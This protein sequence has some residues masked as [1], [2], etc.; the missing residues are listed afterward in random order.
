MEIQLSE[1]DKSFIDKY[2]FLVTTSGDRY[3]VRDPSNPKLGKRGRLEGGNLT[4]LLS[5]AED[6]RNAATPAGF[7]AS[8][9]KTPASTL[10]AK[11]QRTV[12][13]PR[14]STAAPTPKPAP[15]PRKSTRDMSA[16]N[17][18][19]D[20]V[21]NGVKPM[22]V[23]D[24]LTGEGV[25]LVSDSSTY[26]HSAIAKRVMERAVLLGWRPPEKKEDDESA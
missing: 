1:I 15:A 16:M 18:V 3:V 23:Y 26:T 6:A 19:Y 8:R 17:A 21:I 24:V 2:G 9:K 12:A 7:T 11:K 25:K 10:P 14:A 4:S 13:A 20:A 22:D 5:Q